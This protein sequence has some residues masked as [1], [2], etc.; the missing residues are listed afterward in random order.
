VAAPSID[1]RFARSQTEDAETLDARLSKLYQQRRYSDAIPLAEHILLIREK[2]FG[3]DHAEVA[4]SL[5]RLAFLY[6]IEG[7]YSDAEPLYKRALAISEN[8]LGPD[9]PHVATSLYYIAQL[10]EN[11]GRDEDA[12]PLYTGD[13]WPLAKKP[14]VPIT[15]MLR[16][17]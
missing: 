15:P 10:Y 9:H 14:S 7:R 2:T 17:R 1:L 3:L 8:T 4:T 6:A 13:R 5:N 12:E 11:Q 16:R